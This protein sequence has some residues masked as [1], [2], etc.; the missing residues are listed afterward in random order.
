VYFDRKKGST[1]R[2]ERHHKGCTGRWS[3]SI[4][5]DRDGSGMRIWARLTAPTNADLLRKVSVSW[6]FVTRFTPPECP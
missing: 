3:A 1:C 6:P 2:D 4:S 5:I